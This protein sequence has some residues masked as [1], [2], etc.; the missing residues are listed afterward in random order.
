MSFVRT[1]P[2]LNSSRIVKALA[3]TAMAVS[4]VRPATAGFT[5]TGEVAEVMMEA[6]GQEGI[7]VFSHLGNNS[8][9]TLH[10]VTNVDAATRTF[11]YA[12]ASGQTYLGQSVQITTNGWYDQGSA[13]YRWSSLVSSGS[14]SYQVAGQLQFDT[15]T[16]AADGPAANTSTTIDGVEGT[17]GPI[18][19]TFA[20]N[21]DPISSAHFTWKKPDGTP[22]GIRPAKDTYKGNGQMQWEFGKVAANDVGVQ[23]SGFCDATIGGV[24]YASMDI[25][26]AV[27]VPGSLA[28]LCLA[29]VVGR[30]GRRRE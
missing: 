30:R 2:V 20:P 11:S 16:A 22:G 18:T 10:F 27:P 8:W 26:T 7:N 19:W 25:G 29:G 28:L 23:F 13:S 21:G 15:V 1:I 3:C 17:L 12:T 14:T 24:G 9:S 5:Q 6:L 4:M